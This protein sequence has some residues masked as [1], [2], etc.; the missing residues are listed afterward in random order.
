M[1]KGIFFILTLLFFNATFSQE[2]QDFVVTSPNGK[3]KV[4]ILVG[5]KITWS[6]LHEKNQI[7]APSSISMTLDQNEV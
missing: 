2:A 3:I 7:L 5:E 4:S 6:V 1:K